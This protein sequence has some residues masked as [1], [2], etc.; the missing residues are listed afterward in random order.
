M[1]NLL[2]QRYLEHIDR[3][4][5]AADEL[6]TTAQRE[7][8]LA[9]TSSGGTCLTRPALLERGGLAQLE[10]DLIQL[11]AGL[12][13]LPDTLFG[14][15]VGAFARAVGMTPTQVTAVQRTWSPTPTWLGRAD[16]YH[17]GDTFRALEVNV[18]STIGGLDNA[19]LNRAFLTHPAMAEFAAA[20][21]LTYVDTMDRLA[22]LLRSECG[23]PEGEKPLVAVVDTPESFAELEQRLWHSARMLAPYGLEMVPCPIGR[24]EL[25]DGRVWLDGRVVDVVYRLFVPADLRDQAGLDAFDPLLRAVER[26]EVR[27]FAPLDAHLYSS[28]GALALLSDEANRSHLSPAALASLDRFLPWTRMVRPG[29]VTVDGGS[30]DL[31]EYARAAREELILKPTTLYGGTGIVPGWRVD[32]DEWQRAVTGALDGPFVL[33]RRIRPNVEPFPGPD[34]LAP[35]ALTWG[36]FFADRRYAG[37]FLRGAPAGTSDVINRGTGAVVGCCFHQCADEPA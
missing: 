8:D 33:Q 28:K 1:H 9:A 15:D 7:T 26:G 14:G 2:T 13:S 12:T 37:M 20:E 24:I 3:Y 36:A 10:E 11:Y 22:A 21:R 23:V 5:L 16:V 27:L 4:G 30:A 17:E 25:R 19:V 6:V 34:G 32:A 35:L 18:G 29:P 31:L